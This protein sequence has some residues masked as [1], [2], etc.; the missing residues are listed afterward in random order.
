M[1]TKA[2]TSSPERIMLTNITGLINQAREC[3]YLPKPPMTLMA[4][5]KIPNCPLMGT[6]LA[7]K[8][9]LQTEVKNLGENDRNQ[10]V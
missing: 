8:K 5:D 7:I 9:S 4:L 1:T 10:T 6:L 3:D 2:H